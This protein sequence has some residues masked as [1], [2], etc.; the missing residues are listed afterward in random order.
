MLETHQK[1]L[2]E[3]NREIKAER[4]CCQKA[5]DRKLGDER[6]RTTAGESGR[7]LN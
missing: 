7:E 2:K 6:T 4:R 5:R 1:A 3:Q